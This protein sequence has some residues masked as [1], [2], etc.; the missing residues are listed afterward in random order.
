MLNGMILNTNGHTAPQILPK[1]SGSLT[2]S[3]PYKGLMLSEEIQ[4]LHIGRDYG[5][6]QAPSQHL[7]TSIK[8]SVY[9]HGPY[10]SQT[11]HA[12]IEEIN[13][14]RAW[15]TLS[16]FSYLF[17]QWRDRIDE[18]VQPDKPMRVRIYCSTRRCSGT[19]D[20]ISKTGMGILIYRLNEKQIHTE[21][22]SKVKIEIPFSNDAQPLRFD[23]IVMTV[24]TI[25]RSLA[26][27]GL[28]IIP[29]KKQQVPLEQ[30][31]QFRRDEIFGELNS[32]WMSFQEPRGTKDLFF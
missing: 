13:P 27:V 2:M 23:A 7:F 10:L 18:R 12:H 1:I 30:Y 31:V 8:D 3:I 17:T 11:I 28:Q 14:H 32:V 26:K 4:V 5:V 16:R 20:N 6:F 19:I 24:K 21:L 25:G 29:N 15:I 9:L 22:G